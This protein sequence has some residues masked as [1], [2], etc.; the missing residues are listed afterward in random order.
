MMKIKK[1]TFW[2]IVYANDKAKNKSAIESLNEYIIKKQIS[3]CDV[4]NIETSNDSG[5]YCLNLFYWE[6]E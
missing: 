1:V 5:N 4:I 2:D 3:K 6:S